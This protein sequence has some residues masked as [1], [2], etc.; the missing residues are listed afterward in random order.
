MPTSESF[1][2]V[3]RR[4]VIISPKARITEEIAPLIEAQLP[5]VE[6][7]RIRHRLPG[8]IPDLGEPG[9]EVVPNEARHGDQAQ[10]RRRAYGERQLVER[11][12]EDLHR[13]SDSPLAPFSE[14]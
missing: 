9:R 12:R 11:A 10:C 2:N 4:A 7:V 6:P 3:S 13:G 1:P 8:R 14:A 5:G